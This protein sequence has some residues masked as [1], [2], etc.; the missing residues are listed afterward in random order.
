[1]IDRPNDPSIENGYAL[2]REILPKA[3]AELDGPI[4]K[5]F[6]VAH[7]ASRKVMEHHDGP[8]LCTALRERAIH[9]PIRFLPVARNRVPQYARHPFRRQHLDDERIEQPLI[10]ITALSKRAEKAVRVGERPN[11]LLSVA[12][13][14]ADGTGILEKSERQRVGPCMSARAGTRRCRRP[15]DRREPP[16]ALRWSSWLTQPCL[17]H[18]RDAIASAVYRPRL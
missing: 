8:G 6:Q 5:S 14:L 16:G 11:R 4:Q 13:L 15:P 9:P 10:Q 1:M 7:S 18:L 12:N 17:S 3:N 2:R